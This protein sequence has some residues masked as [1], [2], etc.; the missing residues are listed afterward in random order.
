MYLDLPSCWS[1][2]TLLQCLHFDQVSCFHHLTLALQRLIYSAGST[3]LL[4][5]CIMYSSFLGQPSTGLLNHIPMPRHVYIF[6][7]EHSKVH[8]LVLNCLVTT[9]YGDNSLFNQSL[10][11]ILVR[12]H[13]R[14]TN[15]LP[16]FTSWQF[17][18]R[19]KLCHVSQHPSILYHPSTREFRP[20]SLETHLFRL[21]PRLLDIILYSG[22][23]KLHPFT[24][25]FI[26]SGTVIQLFS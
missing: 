20:S 26:C 5:C 6:S 9:C 21:H 19:S 25:D 13:G 10:L 1:T 16:N 2:S 12:P 24:L 3:S 23:Y 14:G 11:R 8:A 4:Y 7:I 18:L 15:F 22:L 17:L